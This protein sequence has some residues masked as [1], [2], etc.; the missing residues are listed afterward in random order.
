MTVISL[1]LTMKLEKFKDKIGT[2]LLIFSNF[3]F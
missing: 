2:N 3:V 1:Y